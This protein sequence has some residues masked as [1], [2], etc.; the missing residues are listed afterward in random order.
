MFGKKRLSGRK[1][2]DLNHLEDSERS[3]GNAAKQTAK[4]P[5]NT[6]CDG[7]R[8][9]GRKFAD[10]IHPEDSERL[11][12]DITKNLTAGTQ[13]TLCATRSG[14]LA[15]SL[16]HRF[17]QKTAS[18]CLV[19]LPKIRWRETQRTLYVIRCST[20]SRGSHEGS[21]T[22]LKNG[23]SLPGKLKDGISLPGRL[24][25]EISLP[26]RLIP[27][28]EES[29]GHFVRRQATW[30]GLQRTLLKTRNGP[31]TA[32]LLLSPYSANGQRSIEQADKNQ[33]ARNKE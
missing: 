25:N 2:A 11:I 4:N 32:S 17:N 15:A 21:L 29:R 12:G 1:I 26:G 13:R 24:G 5:V 33:R 9:T 22:R 23:I 30:R 18:D 10:P 14:S 8:L 20:S 31:P 6:L 16:L 3:F 7:K 27:V 19:T 28:G